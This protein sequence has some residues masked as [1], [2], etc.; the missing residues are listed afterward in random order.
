MSRVVRVRRWEERARAAQ[1]LARL[2]RL[3]LELQRQEQRRRQ[4]E[5]ATS[6]AGFVA[7]LVVLWALLVWPLR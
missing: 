3:Y 5:V 6:V 4:W 2:R 7:L 1:D